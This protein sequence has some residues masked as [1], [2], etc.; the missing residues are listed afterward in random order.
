MLVIPP[1]TL[2]RVVYSSRPYC[3][4]TFFGSLW[5]F[6]IPPRCSLGAALENAHISAADRADGACRNL[7]ILSHRIPHSAW[8]GIQ[9]GDPLALWAKMQNTLLYMFPPF[10][11]IMAPLHR[12]KQGSHW[13]LLVAPYW[14]LSTW[15]GEFTFSTKQ[16]NMAPVPVQTT[17]MG[18]ASDEPDK[19]LTTCNPV[20]L[21][22]IMNARASSTRWAYANMWK[23]LSDRCV[24]QNENTVHCFV[25]IILKSFP[26]SRHLWAYCWWVYPFDSLQ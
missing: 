17:L 4:H 23:L 18:L 6:R 12:I 13:L 21:E 2:L 5:W 10:P 14:P 24:C 3:P 15:Q 22:A 26:F 19:L 20:V 11:L 8:N 9:Y 25:Q 7:A 1:C 16:Y